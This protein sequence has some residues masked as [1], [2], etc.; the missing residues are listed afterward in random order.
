MPFFPAASAQMGSGGKKLSS[1][2]KLPGLQ[3]LGGRLTKP[4]MGPGGKN[5]LVPPVTDPE[6]EKP[7][8][9]RSLPASVPVV[10]VASD[11]LTVRLPLTR[12]ERQGFGG[13]RIGPPRPRVKVPAEGAPVQLAAQ[14]AVPS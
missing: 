4:L 7:F 1:P 5:G 6:R 14:L 13:C 9:S 12:R 10:V 8:R 11:Q 2:M 3:G